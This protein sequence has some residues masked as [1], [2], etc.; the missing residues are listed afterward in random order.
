MR[1]TRKQDDGTRSSPPPP[2][3]EQQQ[4]LYLARLAWALRVRGLAVSVQLPRRAEPWI[5]VPRASGPL[6]VRAALEGERWIFTWGRG[7]DRWVDAL[8]ESAPERVWEVAR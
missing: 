5:S 2:S 3:Q 1:R 6:L 4:F 7:R 8:D